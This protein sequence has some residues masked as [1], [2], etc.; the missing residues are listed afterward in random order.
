[1]WN[2]CP[3]FSRLI[4]LGRSSTFED[5]QFLKSKKTAKQSRYLNKKQFNPKRTPCQEKRFSLNL[6][7]E[8]QQVNT[9]KSCFW[10]TKTAQHLQMVKCN[11]HHLKKTK[12]LSTSREMVSLRVW[13][14]F[15]I[16]QKVPQWKKNRV[17]LIFCKKS[18]DLA[19]RFASRINEN[20]TASRFGDGHLRREP[21]WHDSRKYHENFGNNSL[22]WFY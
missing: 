21:T 2:L 6:I 8:E 18:Y 17:N 4:L 14:L 5:S 19:Q 15:Y 20:K 11:S 13:S 3:K 7:G 1:M 22:R 12:I 10:C 9:I 16:L